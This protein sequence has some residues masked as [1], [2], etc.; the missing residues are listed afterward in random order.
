MR[1]YIGA[2]H[3]GF[4]LKRAIIAYLN[5]ADHEVEDCGDEVM[6]QNDDFPQFAARVAH[7][8]L[9]S[10]DKDAK[11][12]LICGSGQGMA[13]AANRF[14]GIRAAVCWDRKSAEES[15][16]DDDANVLCLPSNHLDIRQAE[17]TTG[18]WL[19]TEFAGAA[20]FTRRIEQIDNL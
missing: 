15:R 20:R 1:V 5:R 2:D 3:R 6:D 8:V 10:E 4:E 18:T 11:G 16:N 12:I 17:D 7:K 14:K 19:K 13:I 9:A